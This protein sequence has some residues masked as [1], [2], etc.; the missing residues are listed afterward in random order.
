MQTIPT[1]LAPTT[2]NKLKKA[3]KSLGSD[4]LLV[5]GF[6]LVGCVAKKGPDR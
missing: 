5:I 2:K 1:A 3:I 4:A 6:L